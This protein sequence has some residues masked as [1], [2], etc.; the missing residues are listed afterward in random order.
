MY[1]CWMQEELKKKKKR[2]A[3]RRVEAGL[4][5]KGGGGGLFGPVENMLI[6]MDPQQTQLFLNG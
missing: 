5:S 3:L 1:G 2:F 4:I 6:L